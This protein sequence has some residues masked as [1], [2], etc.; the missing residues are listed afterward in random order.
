MAQV[1]E[2]SGNA[3][4][5]LV[6]DMGMMDVGTCSNNLQW[7]GLRNTPLSSIPKHHRL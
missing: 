6:G 7:D 2:V 1:T 3:F 5:L 4:W